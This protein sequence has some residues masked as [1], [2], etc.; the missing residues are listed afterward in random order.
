MLQVREHYAEALKKV[1]SAENAKKRVDAELRKLK[2]QD[3]ALTAAFTVSI[4]PFVFC[5]G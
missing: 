4:C 3:C 1:K 5:L 2:V